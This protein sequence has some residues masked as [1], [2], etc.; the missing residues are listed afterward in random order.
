MKKRKFKKQHKTI[1]GEVLQVKGNYNK[2][3]W[4]RNIEPKG[5]RQKKY[6][7]LIKSKDIIFG[8]G[9]A[10]T[11]KSLLACNS[12]IELLIERKASKIILCRPV[13]E[14]GER[15]GYL[16]GDIEQKLNPYLRPL[17]DCL[18]YIFTPNIINGMV[19]DKTIEILPLAF[20]RG[21]TFK[22]SVVILDEAQNCTVEQ[23]KMFLTR[24]GEGSK[25][26]I[27][28]DV[29]QVDLE[30]KK[31]GLQEAYNQLCSHPKGGVIDEIG[32]VIL[33]KEDIIRHPVVAKIIEK[34]NGF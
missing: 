2:N 8:I 17:Y 15:L 13:V 34:W 9:P 33:L 5:D 24:L 26:I 21:I 31:S 25:L 1:V 12:A 23:M 27:N 7:E 6:L 11:G 32:S 29:T 3:L 10:G 4:R 18:S 30:H 20:T 16:P 28:G 22:K 14:S 19:E